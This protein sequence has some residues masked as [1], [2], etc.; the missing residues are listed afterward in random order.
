MSAED[1][2]YAKILDVK[3]VLEDTHDHFNTY[4]ARDLM[5]LIYSSAQ[6]KRKPP[7]ALELLY[8]LE[9]CI[10]EFRNLIEQERFKN[11]KE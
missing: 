8:E 7:A 10:A 2:L 5:N 9:T 6:N 4:S 3:F 11:L 1:V